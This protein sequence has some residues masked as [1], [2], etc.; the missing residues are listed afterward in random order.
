M[1]PYG[2]IM[3]NGETIYVDLDEVSL[4]D[5]VNVS[6]PNATVHFS[7]MLTGKQITIQQ[8]LNEINYTDHPSPM[9]TMEWLE[10]RMREVHTRL[11]SAWAYGFEGSI[12]TPA[13]AG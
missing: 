9:R 12:G 5:R 7:I 8:T 2:V 6:D 11:V 3:P 13:E 1:R 4:I 10:E